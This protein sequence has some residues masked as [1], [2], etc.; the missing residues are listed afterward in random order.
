ML[1]AVRD[2][3]NTCYSLD[4]LTYTHDIQWSLDFLL[5][6]SVV[7]SGT[8]ISLGLRAHLDGS[9]Y[10]VRIDNI[11]G[12]EMCQIPTI[13]YSLVSPSFALGF[14]HLNWRKTPRTVFGQ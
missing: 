14:Q 12:L 4:Q 11:L 13:M 8:F 1:D 9:V 10:G 3:E 2:T 6:R 5:F 7:F